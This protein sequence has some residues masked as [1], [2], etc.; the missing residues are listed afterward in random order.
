MAFGGTDAVSGIDS[1]TSATYA[2]P[3]AAAADVSGS[4]RDIAGNAATRTFT[5]RYDATAPKL[6]GLRAEMETIR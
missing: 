6:G 5:L 3:D 4:C 1:C 2:G